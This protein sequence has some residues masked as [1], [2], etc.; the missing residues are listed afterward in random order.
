MAEKVQITRQVYRK[1]IYQNVIDTNF[2][3]LIQ[4]VTQVED[5]G[6]TVDE[7]FQIYNELFFEIP[8][9]GDINSHQSLINQSS[10]YVGDEYVNPLIAELQAEITSLKRQILNSNETIND[11]TSQLSTLGD[12]FTTIST[13]T[14]TVASTNTTQ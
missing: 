7:F 13:Q 11:L 12:Q 2:S 3:Q 10:Q 4:P 14:N 1:D 9:T 6:P 5:Q 8:K